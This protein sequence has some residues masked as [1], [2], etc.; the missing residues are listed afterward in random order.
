M[1]SPSTCL[2]SFRVMTMSL[3]E[4]VIAN[5]AMISMVSRIMVLGFI[6]LCMFASMRRAMW[7]SSVLG[8]TQ[9]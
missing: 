2:P 1:N 3:A 9:H 4:A 5:D 8:S 7:V 6:D